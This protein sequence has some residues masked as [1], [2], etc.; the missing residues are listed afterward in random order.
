M[1]FHF[2]HKKHVLSKEGLFSTKIQVV[3]SALHRH[4]YYNITD[5]HNEAP[6]GRLIINTSKYES[7]Y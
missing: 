4:N 3:Y 6:S 5:I 2:P 1:N 7:T